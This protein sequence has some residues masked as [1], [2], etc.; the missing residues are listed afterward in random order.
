VLLGSSFHNS[1]LPDFFETE[2]VNALSEPFT[3]TGSNRMTDFIFALLGA[4]VFVK[5]LVIGDERAAIRILGHSTAFAS[6][7]A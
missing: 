1:Q 5:L 4:L 7:D 3:I 2:L 6:G